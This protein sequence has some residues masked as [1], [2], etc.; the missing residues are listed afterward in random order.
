MAESG[1][2]PTNGL[3][4]KFFN[5][6]TIQKAYNFYVEI[7]NSLKQPNQFSS[8][9]NSRLLRFENYGEFP[10]TPHHVKSVTLPGYQTKFEMFKVGNMNIKHTMFDF[11]SAL[12]K[13]DFAEDSENTIQQFIMWMLKRRMNENGEY[14]D[15]KLSSPL[16]ISVLVTD[17][18]QDAVAKYVFK[19]CTFVS[20]TEP[21][22]AY[23]TSDSINISIDFS[24]KYI[25]TE[26]YN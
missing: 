1:E 19:Q 13:I 5:Y 22:Y 26:F 20:S 8:Q 15:I 2:K 6:K 24:F 21:N 7:D 3:I 10:V 17:D 16:T 12:L 25:E 14:Y 4:N 18:R 23:D 9:R 11:E